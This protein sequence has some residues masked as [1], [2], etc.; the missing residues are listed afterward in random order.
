MSLQVPT[1]LK[2]RKSGDEIKGRDSKKIATHL[3]DHKHGHGLDGNYSKEH[4]H[5]QAH[6][7]ESSDGHGQDIKSSEDFDRTQVLAEARE[8]VRKSREKREHW[9]QKQIRKRRRLWCCSCG[10]AAGM[11]QHDEE[12]G[13]GIC[14][15]CGHNRCSE[16]LLLTN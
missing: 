3:Q 1:A 7:R 8:V 14:A 13:G 4:N 16:C 5:T 11:V 10:K 6:D 12:G 9:Q 2:K 15:E